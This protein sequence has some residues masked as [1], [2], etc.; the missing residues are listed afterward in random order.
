MRSSPPLTGVLCVG[1]LVASVA[2]MVLVTRELVGYSDPASQWAPA[3]K[4]LA[5]SLV[6][7][8]SYLGWKTMPEADREATIELRRAFQHGANQA[9][10]MMV[11][12]LSVIAAI[13]AAAI[14]WTG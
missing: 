14:Y 1:M 5:T 2:Y 3:L 10:L 6:G 11:A 13:V 12:F 9:V 8:L 7:Y 4:L